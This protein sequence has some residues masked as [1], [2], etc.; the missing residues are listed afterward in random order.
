MSDEVGRRLLAEEMSEMHTIDP[1]CHMTVDP[2][3]ATLKSTH[4]GE[5][6]YFC[7]PHCKARFDADPARYAPSANGQPSPV[8][9]SANGPR[10]TPNVTEYT[11]PMHPEIVRN[12]PGSCPTCGMALEPRTAT[13]EDQA[14]P[15]LV[16]MRRRFMA[17]AVLTAPLVA[18]A[19]SHLMPA[20]LQLALAAPVV[21][22]GGWP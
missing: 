3:T 22:W 21:L 10:P 17:S 20:W 7:N 1:I 15:E 19:M 18:G 14:N 5:T 16:D 9:E 13:L 4:G 6:Y 2:A 11:C 8:N 12:G